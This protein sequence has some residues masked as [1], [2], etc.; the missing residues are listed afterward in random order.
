MF[1]SGIWNMNEPELQKTSQFRRGSQ[2]WGDFSKIKQLENVT[3]RKWW[4]KMKELPCLC[5]A[6]PGS[7]AR[8]SSALPEPSEPACSLSSPLGRAHRPAPH[9]K[10]ATGKTPRTACSWAVLSWCGWGLWGCERP[11]ATQASQR[12]QHT[13]QYG[14]FIT[15][16]SST[17]FSL[18]TLL[19]SWDYLSGPSFWG[20]NSDLSPHHSHLLRAFVGCASLLA[21][22]QIQLKWKAC[23]AVKAAIKREESMRTGIWLQH[24]IASQ[25]HS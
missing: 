1:K 15:L 21:P 24:W 11:G 12:S 8:S 23:A 2:K 4:Q 18:R 17:L 20:S 14:G 9:C 19:S 3:V 6:K 10:K 16:S 7:F 25:I 13:L 22:H 5:F